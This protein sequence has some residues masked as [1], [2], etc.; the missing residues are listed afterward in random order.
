MNVTTTMSRTTATGAR[1]LART[2][3]AGG[4]RHGWFVAS[5][6]DRGTRLASLVADAEAM[7]D[8]VARTCASHGTD[9]RSVGASFLLGHL[10]WRVTGPLAIAY[11]EHQR[12]PAIDPGTVLVGFDGA[13]EPRPPVFATPAFHA[14]P[15]DPAADHP[16]AAVVDGAGELRRAF[17]DTVAGT[18]G[19]LVA[20]LKPWARRGDRTQWGGLSDTV[21]SSLWVAG[22]ELGDEQRGV[23]EA[24]LILDGTPPFTGT[25]NFVEVTHAG[26]TCARRVRNT[27]CL[28]YRLD[29]HGYCVSCPLEDEGTRRSRWRANREEPS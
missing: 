22:R 26:T 13:G 6:G 7:G 8:L 18:L 2:L 16:D 12:V 25:A 4:S 17:R 27:C 9:D 15:D 21:A 10:A 24:E 1:P 14:L 28:A 3:V 20:A 5:L 11:L 29:G 19:G 23:R